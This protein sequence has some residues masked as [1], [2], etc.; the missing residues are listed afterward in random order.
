MDGLIYVYLH[1][2]PETEE[3]VYVGH[4]TNERAWRCTALKT[5]TTEDSIYGHRSREH[6]D[7]C[8][9]LIL[10]GYVPNDWVQIIERSLDKTYACK[11]E[12]KLIREIKPKFNKAMGQKL[13]KL[14]KKQLEKAENMR[15]QGYFYTNI[16]DELKVATMTVWRALNGKN[17]NTPNG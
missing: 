2:H 5:T 6:A 13:L 10:E 15:S 12:Q 11:L 8:Q 1:I 7:W 3:V 14:N 16:A 4:G 17:Q 9:A